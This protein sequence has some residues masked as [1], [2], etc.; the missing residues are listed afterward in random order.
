MVAL[1]TYELNLKSHKEIIEKASIDENFK[2]KFLEKCIEKSEKLEHL[3]KCIQWAKN[4]HI[5][6]R[7]DNIRY[8][9]LRILNDEWIPSR[10]GYEN[11]PNNMVE[12]MELL[13]REF[14]Q[15]TANSL[16]SDLM[17]LPKKERN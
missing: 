16:V 10:H 9:W 11:I 1:A 7:L 13:A 2:Q 17:K 15:E 3:N 6:F 8:D 5:P 12:F 4:N 14:G